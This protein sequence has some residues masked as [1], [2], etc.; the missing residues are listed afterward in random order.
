MIFAVVKLKQRKK[1]LRSENV[2]NIYEGCTQCSA[3]VHV[4]VCMFIR[5]QS[6]IIS[7]RYGRQ[8]NIQSE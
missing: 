5:N 6:L 3:Y 1:T 2:F 8:K 4:Y 7:S